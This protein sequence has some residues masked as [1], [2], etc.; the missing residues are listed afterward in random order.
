MLRMTAGDGAAASAAGTVREKAT[1]RDVPRARICGELFG[2][3][4]PASHRHQLADGGDCFV[5]RSR[6][7]GDAGERS[8]GCRLSDDQCQR[9]SAGRGSEHDVVIG[10]ERARATV[11]GNRRARL[12]DVEEFDR[13]YEYQL[14][15]FA[16]PGD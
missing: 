3:L 2:N 12:D 10:G 9:E 7:R 8:A 14:T 4:H 1:A 16:R 6:I 11:Y 5:R 15:V 13:K